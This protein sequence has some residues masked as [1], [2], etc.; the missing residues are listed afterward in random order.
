MPVRAK[1]PC[2]H[3]GCGAL[4]DKP[5]YCETHKKAE[6]K[7]FDIE[8]GTSTQRGYG[9]RWQKAR[10]AYLLKHPLCVRHEEL[11]KVAVA[12]VVDHKVPHKGDM[13][14]FWDSSN[15]QALCKE[16]HDYKTATEDGGFRMG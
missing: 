2:R 15:W 9:Y 10:V 16:C 8:R 6:R 1:S 3:A 12:T 11:G 13:V 5:G 7:R 4:V 14:L